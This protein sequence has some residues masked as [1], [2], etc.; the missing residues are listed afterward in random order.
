MAAMRGRT[1]SRL[2]AAVAAS[3]ALAACL[4]LAACGSSNSTVSTRLVSE[5]VSTTSSSGAF[6]IAIGGSF[7]IPQLNRP[8][9]LNGSGVVDPRTRSGK[10][11]V[12]LSSLSGLLGGQLGQT[13]GGALKIDEVFA[14]H[15]IYMKAPFYARFLPKG[16]SWLRLDIQQ[17][18]RKLGIDVSQLTQFSGGDPRQTLDQLRAVSGG[19]KK[20]GS[21]TVRGVPTTHYRAN[22]DLKRYPKLLPAAQ[23]ATAE[24]SVKRLTQLTHISTIPEDLWIDAQKRVRR[25]RLNYSFEPANAPKGQKLTFDETL[26]LYDFGVREPIAVPPANQTVDFTTLISQLSQGRGLGRTGP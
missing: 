17:F 12:D 3:A 19:V 22:V 9:P 23:R 8:I 2:V 1:P 11:T 25:I 26:D 7:R 13:S 20:I 15:V 16:K 21:E 4:A 5:A 10:V 14:N 18:G 24:Q 6:R